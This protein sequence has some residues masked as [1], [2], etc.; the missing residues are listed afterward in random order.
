MIKSAFTS[1]KQVQDVA[2]EVLYSSDNVKAFKV[3]IKEGVFTVI[4]YADRFS[5]TPDTE[6]YYQRY[7][8]AVARHT[9][10]YKAADKYVSEYLRRKKTTEK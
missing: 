7:N 1:S 4:D 3:S 5:K 9:P 2:V 6:V 10:E 8:D